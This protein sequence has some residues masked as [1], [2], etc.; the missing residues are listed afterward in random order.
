MNDSRGADHQKHQ[1]HQKHNNL[2]PHSKRAME[3]DSRV[4]RGVD[5]LGH[6]R[7]S[8]DG[9]AIYYA[10]NV[11]T[12]RKV[13]TLL[14]NGEVV[15]YEGEAGKERKV[16]RTFPTGYTIFTRGPCES[17]DS[18]SR[19]VLFDG[20]RHFYEG[21]PGAESKVMTLFWRGDLHMTRF[22][23]SAGEEHKV[24]DIFHS[25]VCHYYKGTAGAERMAMTLYT[26][27]D[28]LRVVYRGSAGKESKFCELLRSGVRHF[29]CRKDGGDVL[30]R[31][32]NMGNKRG[33]SAVDKSTR[34]DGEC[35][36]C[37]EAHVGVSFSP[38]GHLCMCEECYHSIVMR[39]KGSSFACP[40][41]KEYAC[42]ATRVYL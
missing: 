24:W 11:G 17:E 4:K 33:V 38:C 20:T 19:T 13:K 29:Y 12:E 28:I 41:C 35:C 42:W 30:V 34:L 7:E 26:T 40:I 39:S 25:G 1:K 22:E 2:H 36:V 18:M 8:E 31:S 32:D 21:A 16:K 5:W 14:P 23:G 15:L 9:S 6:R 3:S 10:G 27:G 37:L